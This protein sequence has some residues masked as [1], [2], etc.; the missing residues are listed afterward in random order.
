MSRIVGA[1]LIVI[2]VL[3]L[4]GGLFFFGTMVGRSNGFGSAAPFGARLN[5]NVYGPGQMMAGQ[6]GDGMMTRGPNNGNGY[7]GGMMRNYAYNNT[8]LAPL[9]MDQARA[10]AGKY[11]ATLNNSDLAIAEVMIFNNNAYVA[12][13][14]TSTGYG[15][16]EL[17]VDPTSQVAYPEMGPNSMWNLKYASLNHS[18]MG[19]R[20]YGMMG[21]WD[22]RPSTPLDVPT[23]MPVSSAQA[24]EAAKAYLESHVPGAVA[25]S[26]PMQFYGYYTLDFTKD[27]K[28]AG[29]L[30]VNGYTGQVFLHTW[31]GTFLEEA[32]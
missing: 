24:I 5:N 3:A 14:E 29:M 10:A 16:F 21:G 13:K 22:Y 8:N 32:E 26:D 19:G 12:V 9:T 2:A 11:L 25:S 31:H 4:A 17:L 7:A 20:G 1:T 28:V 18:N 23:D 15:A 27:G 30:S 6:R